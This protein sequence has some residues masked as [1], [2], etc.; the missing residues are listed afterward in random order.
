MPSVARVGVGSEKLPT[1][2]LWRGSIGTARI[3]CH[4]SF[5]PWHLLS[6]LWWVK[7]N[8]HLLQINVFWKLRCS[9]VFTNISAGFVANVATPLSSHFQRQKKTILL[10]GWYPRYYWFFDRSCTF[11]ELI[12]IKTFT[13]LR[14]ISYI[15]LRQR[16]IY[17]TWLWINEYNIAIWSM[18]YYLLFR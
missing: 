13:L 15:I 11:D 12:L 1:T 3:N 16:R 17:V 5:T 7:I 18:G 6:T 9:L 2:I 4:F 10:V 14:R 8:V